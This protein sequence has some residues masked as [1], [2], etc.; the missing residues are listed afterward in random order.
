M[1]NRIKNILRKK[2][3]KAFLLLVVFLNILNLVFPPPKIKD[4]SKTVY[5][6]EK[7]LLNAYLTKDD[8]WRLRTKIDEVTPQLLEAIIEKE[9]SW[10]Y[11]HFGVNPISVFRAMYQNLISSKRVSGA[12]T[13]TMQLARILE[14]D[15]RTYL[16]KIKEVLRAVQYELR[17]SKKEIL[18]MYLSNLPFGGNI[19]GVKSAS[20]IY[21]NRPPD[22]LSLSQTVALTVIPNNPNFLRPDKSI[23]ALNRIKNKWLNKFKED[24]IFQSDEIEDALSEDIERTRSE[25]PNIA[26]HFSLIVKK[27][28]NDDLLISSLNL[29][30]QSKS[31]LLL[32][33][34]VE[35]VRSRG[36]SN[37]AVLV[38]DNKSMQVKV[39][40]GSEDFSDNNS[41]GQVNGITSVRSPGSALKPFLYAKAF[42]E[43][44]LTPQNRLLDIPT[45]FGGYQ[46]ENYDTKFN[47]W[48][49]ADFALANSLNVP[50]V[51]LLRETG[52]SNF[53]NLLEQN[54][55]KSIGENKTSLGLST[56]LGGCGVTL[57]ELTKFYTTFSNNGELREIQ[58]LANFNVQNGKP[59]FN[60]AV[61]YMIAAIL[62]KIERPDLALEFIDQSK[63][64]KI[65]WK[66]G[67]S[68]GKRDAWAIGF[69]P[70]YTIGV[71][72]GNFDGKGSP[73]LSGAEMAVPLLFDL[74]NV[75]DYNSDKKWF[76]QPE[77]VIKREVCAET[78][79][80]PQTTCE[81]LTYDY[82]IANISSLQ[83]CDLLKEFIVN[84][85]ERIE[86]CTDCIPP[87]NYKSKL[88]PYY[89]AELSHWYDLN[90]IYY[91]KIPAHNVN[92]TR[93]FKYNL[94]VILSPSDE[95]EYFLEGNNP[96]K[97][98]LQ[99][100]SE[101]SVTEHYWYVN[102]E[103]IKK[104]KAGTKLFISIE[105][106]KNIITCTDNKGRSS[107][108]EIFVK[109][110]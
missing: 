93:K 42:N 91:E 41:S 4:Y 59:V 19:E 108:I 53:L 24:E 63:L 80:L 92:C 31:E 61:G 9:D 79:M 12:S 56:I 103:L 45:D 8:K 85:E 64:P 48:V 20:Y 6:S 101:A 83:R 25:M 75:I 27:K 35:R 104:V 11:W 58:Y 99:A 69:N 21:F 90:S 29:E 44:A 81:N 77:S 105:K 100:A 1:H 2:K 72:M 96:Q 50:A 60:K 66:T 102:N 71:W 110:Y 87:K 74:F 98:L 84:T 106:G 46:P 26:P 40:C 107:E 62:S 23:E 86:Y 43:G 89:K 33:N 37:G 10:F 70:N 38:I 68:Y 34:Y 94:P 13:I 47:G 32:S 57:E 36:V 73:Y 28:F 7:T 22:K 18:E 30:M 78:G 65:A 54:G 51:R 3:V 52:L 5:S 49:T 76:D 16:V 82:S 97:I 88:Y 55:F 17:F 14:P 109:Y 39:Y 95:Y 15:D 67:T